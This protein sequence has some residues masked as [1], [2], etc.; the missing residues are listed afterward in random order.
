MSEAI[1]EASSATPK[2]VAEDAQMRGEREMGKNEK[3]PSLGRD[4]GATGGE[5][6]TKEGGGTE[7]GRAVSRYKVALGGPEMRRR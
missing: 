6:K 1:F 7:R 5:K 2:R 3:S 4:E